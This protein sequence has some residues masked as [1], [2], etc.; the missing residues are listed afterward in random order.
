M[1]NSSHAHFKIKA[2]KKKEREKELMG[3]DN[4][5]AVTGGGWRWE[6]VWGG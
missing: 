5:M 2:E 6:K 4:G 3:M 1:Q